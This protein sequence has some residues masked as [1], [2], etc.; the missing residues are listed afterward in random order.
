MLIYGA[1][2][3]EFSIRA[4]LSGFEIVNLASLVVRHQFKSADV[5]KRLIAE[6]RIKIVHNNLRF[7]FLYL[8]EDMAL[9]MMRLLA[10]QFPEQASEAFRLVET[11]DVFE[12]RDKL[13]KSLLHDFAWFVERFALKDQAGEPIDL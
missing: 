11:S 2:E 6:R 13:E 12:R 5:R 3:P 1:A 8:S 10:W 7:G 4:W 9:R